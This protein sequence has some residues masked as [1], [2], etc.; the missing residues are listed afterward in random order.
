MSTES[1]FADAIA[2]QKD[3][4]KKAEESK[5]D[6]GSFNFNWVDVEYLGMELDVLKAFRIWGVPA[7]KRRNEHDPKIVLMSQVLKDEGKSFQKVIWP[8]DKN[9]LEEKGKY[10]PDP[11]WI[12]TRLREAVMESNW[13]DYTSAN[14]GTKDEKGDNV[15]ESSDGK[16]INERTK[17]SGRYVDVHHEKEC[18]KL[19]RDN[20]LISKKG[21]TITN[22]IYPSARVIMNVLDRMD[23]WCKTNKKYK[24]L[25]NSLNVSTFTDDSGNPQTRAYADT[26][27][28]KTAYDKILNHFM[29][30]RQDWYV[31]VAVCKVKANNM[32]DWEILESSSVKLPE[33]LK[34]I[35]SDNPLTDEEEDYV[36]N[37]LDETNK[38]TSALSLKKNHLAKFRSADLELGTNFLQELDVLCK[39]EKEE[40]AKKMKDTPP[41]VTPEVIK[42]EVPVA[43]ETPAVENVPETPAPVETPPVDVPVESA[44]KPRGEVAKEEGIDF[45]VLPNYDKIDD[46]DKEDLKK[47][48]ESIVDGK[49]VLKEGTGVYPCDGCQESLPNTL[50]NCPYCGMKFS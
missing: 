50:A 1:L 2:V 17:R 16:I 41:V 25:T 7:E 34:G 22:N 26:G 4:K 15:I 40:Y 19:F 33:H 44:R 18:Y 13:T 27:I 8:V 35:M 47:A 43:E 42:E 21:K 37:D 38:V 14:V 28:S 49:L 10:Q 20:F 36:L 31:D 5:G 48:T 46:L 39:K 12:F 29:R 45:S 3:Q 6:G 9:A 24:V 30:F 11:N 32:Y 23:D